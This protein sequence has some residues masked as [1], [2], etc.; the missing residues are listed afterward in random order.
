M[1]GSRNKHGSRLVEG[2]CGVGQAHLDIRQC[3]SWTVLFIF[4]GPLVY[5]C[6]PGV[7]QVSRSEYVFRNPGCGCGCGCFIVIMY[8]NHNISLPGNQFKFPC[9]YLFCLIWGKKKI[10]NY[11]PADS[12][13]RCS[14]RFLHRSHIHREATGFVPWEQA[15]LMCLLMIPEGK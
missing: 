7:S 1:L 10:P 3:V 14:H 11:F 13:S 6:R 5:L 12:L 2:T 4:V 15:L 8:L 9:W